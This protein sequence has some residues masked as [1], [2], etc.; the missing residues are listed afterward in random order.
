MLG[1][2]DYEVREAAAWALGE[3]GYRSAIRPLIDA[4]QF[5]YGD[6]AQLANALRGRTEGPHL[7]GERQILPR[8]QREVQAAL[9][10]DMADHSSRCGTLSFSAALPADFA[11]RRT[12]RASK[13]VQ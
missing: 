1:D 13:A 4:L 6:K 12:Q 2:P 7:C 11:A 8:R 5:T 9:V 3:L 10:P